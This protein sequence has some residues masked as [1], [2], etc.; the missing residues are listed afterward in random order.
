MTWSFLLPLALRQQWHQQWRCK[1]KGQVD[2][3]MGVQEDSL[4]INFKLNLQFEQCDSVL[5]P[6]RQRWRQWRCR[7]K[8]APNAARF[9]AIRT[10]CWNFFLSLKYL[11][12]STLFFAGTLMYIFFA[13]L[14][15]VP[16]RAKQER[17]SSFMY[18]ARRSINIGKKKLH[19]GYANW[20]FYKH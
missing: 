10:Q 19:A 4:I 1:S 3:A 18:L 2:G 20:L 5:P 14:L 16:R 7:R 12:V 17:L 15:Y 6:P 13:F 9:S 8:R 11:Q